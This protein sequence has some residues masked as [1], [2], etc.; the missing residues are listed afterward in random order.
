[1]AGQ[2]PPGTYLSLPPQHWG[3]K[4]ESPQLAFCMGVAIVFMQ[5]IDKL[6]PWGPSAPFYPLMFPAYGSDYEIGKTLF[7]RSSVLLDS[8]V[9]KPMSALVLA[10]HC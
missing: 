1:M 6:F 9:S 2:Q 8:R 5:A 10:I 4:H 7:I 3:L